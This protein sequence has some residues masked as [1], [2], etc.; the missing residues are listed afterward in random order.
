MRLDPIQIA[1]NAISYGIKNTAKDHKEG[2]YILIRCLA[3]NAKRTEYEVV[4]W[5]LNHEIP[6]TGI[7][8]INKDQNG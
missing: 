2:T 7:K 8:E 4:T 5:L 6:L 3:R 1:Y